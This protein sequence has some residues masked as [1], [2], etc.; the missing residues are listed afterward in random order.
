MYTY[1]YR[2]NTTDSRFHDALGIPPELQLLG[3]TPGRIFIYLFIFFF[4]CLR[5]YLA[6]FFFFF[7]CCCFFLFVNLNILEVYFC[8]WTFPDLTVNAM[9][10]LL[11]GIKIS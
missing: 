11:S 4:F 2:I 7:F 8:F 6:F 1:I 9:S 5:F 10:V 3:A